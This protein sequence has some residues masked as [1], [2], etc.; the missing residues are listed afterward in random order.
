MGLMEDIQGW[1]SDAIKATGNIPKK[2]TYKSATPGGAAVYDPDTQTY[3]RAETVS[4]KQ[5]S[6]VRATFTRSQI[7]NQNVLPQ[8][9]R[10]IM[11]RKDLVA[12]G[13][14]DEPKP[15]DRILDGTTHWAVI[16][17]LSDPADAHYDVQVRRPG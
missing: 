1:T 4:T 17:M 11:A 2:V 15:D 13:I 12:A 5:V 14:T 16:N 6:A 3:T 7:D 9:R 10:Y 8:D